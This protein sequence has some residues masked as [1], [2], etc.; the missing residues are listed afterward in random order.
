MLPVAPNPFLGVSFHGVG[1]MLRANCYAPQKYIRRWSW[2]IFWMTQAAWCWLLWPII[3]AVCTIPQLGQ[4]LAESPQADH[5]PGVP[6]G[7]GLR[8]GRDG[9]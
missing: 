5:G 1:A 6:L 4:V 7:H 9:L 2:E 8:R 3:G